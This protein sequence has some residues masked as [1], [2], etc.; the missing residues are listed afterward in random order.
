MEYLSVTKTPNRKA[1]AMVEFSSIARGVCALDIITKAAEV[2]IL[3]ALTICPGK[4]LILFCGELDA[5]SASLEAARQVPSKIGEF[6][7]GSP[8]PDIFQALGR[9]LGLMPKSALALIETYSAACAIKAAD[10]ALKAAWADIAQIRIAQGM[11]GKSTV[12]LTGK[13]AEVTA[14]VESAKNEASENGRLMDVAVIPNPDE[15]ML[16]AM[17][18]VV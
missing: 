15:K 2:E 3:T 6:V 10:T 18:G 8:H 14:A 11:C 1:L 12:I 9:T 7:L 16:A 13:L 4:Y 17:V 5:V